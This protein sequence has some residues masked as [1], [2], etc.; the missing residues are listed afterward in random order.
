MDVKMIWLFVMDR[1]MNQGRTE[2][3]KIKLTDFFLVLLCFKW[4]CFWFPKCG[5]WSDFIYFMFPDSSESLLSDMYWIWHVLWDC[6]PAVPD[7]ATWSSDCLSLWTKRTNRDF[8]GGLV[9]K[10]P[11][12]QCNDLG[13]IPGR[14][15]RSH[16]LQL[17]VHVPQLK[18]PHAAMKT[19]NPTSKTLHSQI[20]TNKK[21]K[22]KNRANSISRSLTTRNTR[23]IV[24]L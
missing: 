23:L 20:N 15:T 11:C 4:F 10:T 9:A 14:G 1:K 8:P 2:N 7:L 18:I 17:R 13:S 21:L 16:M 12:F 24:S 3:W 19:K 22:K 6:W 5:V